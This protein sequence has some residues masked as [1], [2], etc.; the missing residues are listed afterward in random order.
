LA[1]P[2][3]TT[4]DEP[5]EAIDP[6]KI[7]IQ[8]G[9]AVVVMMTLLGIVGLVFKEPT[10]ALARSFVDTLGRAGIFLGFFIP[11]SA[12]IPIPHEAIL[13]FGLLGGL[14]F[15]E[16]VVLAT[17]GSLLGATVGFGIGRTLSHTNIFKRIMAGK[18]AAAREA[19]QRWGALGVLLG[20][21][22]PIPYSLCAWAAGAL[23]MGFGRFIL[24]SQIRWFRVAFYLWLI[25][26]G[27]IRFLT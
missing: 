17:V 27:V 12:P 1:D 11:D 14:H 16:I 9:L 20:A 24:V 6:R 25:E 19:V 5:V 23:G 4:P 3:T 7:L 26:V 8:V 22:T 10:L 13:T 21:T 18:G 15:W 2:T